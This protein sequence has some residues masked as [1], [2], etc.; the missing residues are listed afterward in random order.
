MYA[1]LV[2]DWQPVF[3]DSD[4]ENNI[5]PVQTITVAGGVND[6]ELALNGEVADRF[7]GSTSEKW[8]RFHCV[9]GRSLLVEV[10]APAE[11]SPFDPYAELYSP[12]SATKITSGDEDLG[13]KDSHIMVACTDDSLYKL[14][15][16]YSPTAPTANRFGS[17]TVRLTPLQSILAKPTLLSLYPGQQTTLAAIGSFDPAITETTATVNNV[18]TWAVVDETI[19]T[20]T[21]AGVVTV[22]P[23]VRSGLTDVLVIPK[24]TRLS[25]VSIPLRVTT[26]IPGTP[27]GSDDELPMDIPAPNTLGMT[28]IIH[29]PDGGFLDQI[30]VGLSI[31]HTSISALRVKLISPTGRQVRLQLAGRNRQAP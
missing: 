2:A 29:V 15:V 9:R 22:S 25:G 30:A 5:S 19:A 3:H 17:Y 10:S 4:R 23:L 8:Y 27:Y 20:I 31:T 6:V 18:V 14:K 16:K 24:D 26:S 21:A 1:V 13:N 7:L 12:L 11:V 28:S